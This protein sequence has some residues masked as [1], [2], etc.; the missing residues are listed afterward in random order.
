MKTRIKNKFEEIESSLYTDDYNVARY[1]EAF[2]K[3]VRPLLVCFNPEIRDNI[4]LNILKIKDKAT[5]KVTE[6]LKEIT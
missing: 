3:K 1:L 5:K 2:N 4:L 6:R